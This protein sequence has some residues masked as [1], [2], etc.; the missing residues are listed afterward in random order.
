MANYNPI[1]EKRDRNVNSAKPSRSP[2]KKPSSAMSKTV[3]SKVSIPT[4]KQ[5]IGGLVT[6]SSKRATKEAFI[7][8]K[9]QSLQKDEEEKSPEVMSDDSY[10]SFENCEKAAEAQI[11]RLS[12][13][14]TPVDELQNKVSGEVEVL[15]QD[16]N[17]LYGPNPPKSLY[18]V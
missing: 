16:D 1:R 14:H 6:V 4:K 7:H 17:P 12:G 2:L 18:Q 9:L 15:A 13:A 5:S 11:L 10:K 8:K 3:Q